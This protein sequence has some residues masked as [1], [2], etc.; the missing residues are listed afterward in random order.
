MGEHH[1]CG[2]MG[3][4]VLSFDELPTLLGQVENILISPPIGVVT[5]DPKDGKISPTAQL[6]IGSQFEMFPTIETL[7]KP[8]ISNCTATTRWAEISN[9]FYF[10]G[11]VGT[12]KM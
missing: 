6:N 12:M 11:N 1:S 2:I 7:N 9:V 8:D 10:S 3:N 4:H 5:D